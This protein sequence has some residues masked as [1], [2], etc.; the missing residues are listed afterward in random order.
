MLTKHARFGVI[1]D[2]HIGANPFNENKVSMK[3]FIDL[4]M[5]AL[6]DQ[7]WDFREEGVTHVVFVG[8][9]FDMPYPSQYMLAKLLKALR[10]YRKYFQFYFFLGNHEIESTKDHA[11]VALFELM[12]WSPN[13]HVYVASGKHVTAEGIP[14]TFLSWPE[15][16]TDNPGLVFMHNE[17]KGAKRDNGSTF[18]DGASFDRA[19]ALANNQFFVSGHL[20]TAQNFY[21][22]DPVKMSGKERWYSAGMIYPGRFGSMRHDRGEFDTYCSVEVAFDNVNKKW[23][24]KTNF[25]REPPH[26]HVQ[27][28]EFK[29]RDD[30]LDYCDDL[31]RNYYNL[32]HVSVVAK[33]PK[34]AGYTPTPEDIKQYPF[35]RVETLRVTD[36]VQG[37]VNS[38]IEQEQQTKTMSK[39]TDGWIQS[40]AG[41]KLKGFSLAR[42]KSL[43]SKIEK[44]NA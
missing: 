9:T 26:W 20:H 35:V 10:S 1:A 31:A 32:N 4:Q 12:N 14:L 43:R 17:F 27:S 42:F 19:Q 37:V 44:P 29:L 24:F 41:S 7:L 36:T 39:Y 23:I 3:E 6:G 21:M 40:F 33:I 18:E 22:P 2:L 16:K 8:D 30:F 28:V 38:D 5:E 15:T 13:I 25:R 11:L 34:A